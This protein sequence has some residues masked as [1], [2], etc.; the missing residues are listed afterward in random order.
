[1]TQADPCMDHADVALKEI[2]EGKIGYEILDEDKVG[3]E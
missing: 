3:K 2:S 1:M